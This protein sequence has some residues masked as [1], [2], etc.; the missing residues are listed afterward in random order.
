MEDLDDLQLIDTNQ[1]KSKPPVKNQTNAIQLKEDFFAGAEKNIKTRKE[2]Q[3]SELELD[4]LEEAVSESKEKPKAGQGNKPQ[5]SLKP[6]P[7]KPNLLLSNG[8]RKTTKDPPSV[9]A[10]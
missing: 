3:K 7:S 8:P 4:F 9:V 5:S 1:Q 6:A 10:H 2:G